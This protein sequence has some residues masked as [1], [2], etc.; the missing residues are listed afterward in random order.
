M[1]DA[2]GADAALPSDE[3][4]LVVDDDHGMLA[5]L[6]HVLTG[7]GYR[8]VLA[9]SLDEARAA[10]AES[11]FELALVDLCI[12]TESGADLA[13][14]ISEHAPETA[15]VMVSAVDEPSIAEM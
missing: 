5:L 6:R 1:T 13:Q 15:V 12:G 11:T 8:C 3:R 7:A 9:G 14:E 2:S 4:I 10:L